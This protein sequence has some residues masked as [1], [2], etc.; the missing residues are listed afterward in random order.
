MGQAG[1]SL[2]SAM[3][4]LT[5]AR[6]A[7]VAAQF[8]A[9]VVAARLLDPAGMGVFG[10]GQTVGWVVAIAANGG[11]NIAAIYFLGRR[12]DERR[13]LV[14][15]LIGLG[16]G[17]VGVGIAMTAIAAPIVSV[18]VLDGGRPLLFVGAAV[19][20]VATIGYEVGGAL[21]LGLERRTPYV[22]ADILRSAGTLVLTVVVLL[23]I[24]RTAEGYLL[25]AGVGVLVPVVF[26]LFVVRRDVGT[27][28]PAYDRAF[29]GEALRTGLAGQVGNVLTF[30]NLRLDL[31]LV[32]A[33]LRFESAGVYFV[34]T[35]VSEVVG[36][37][38]TAAASM[39]FPHV[40][41]QEDRRATA[42]TEKTARLTLLATFG[43]AVVLAL[44]SVPVLTVFF[45]ASYAAGAT[46]LVILL[47]SM[48]PLALSR[49]L[50]ADL[51]GRG[52]PGLVSIGT[53]AGAV[54]TVVADLALI[55]PF[56]IEGAAIAS[57]LAYATSAVLLAY[58]YR[59]ETNGRLTALVPRPRD[60]VDLIGFARDRLRRRPDASDVPDA[61]D[62]SDASDVEERSDDES[63]RRA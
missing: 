27:L 10:V 22:V 55:P 9:S 32:P 33:L 35:R 56:G 7:A 11:L 43:A 3:V 36:Q 12:P 52:R 17:A 47:G 60:L 49:V 2:G 41:G 40:A 38:S 30:L 39:L 48:L 6:L 29:T 34:A 5:G 15:R 14:R 63:G 28:R 59:R 31:L 18:T 50:A 44:L 16:L 24:W 8:L 62:A 19:L 25:A 57:V 46:A 54:V 20:A 23:V 13:Q 45:G 26:A 37:A 51:K 21:L 42:M 53:G 61:S 58:W 1:R 4:A